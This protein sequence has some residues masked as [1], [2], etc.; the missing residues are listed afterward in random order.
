MGLAG[1]ATRGTGN[2][3]GSRSEFTRA[4]GFPI[5]TNTQSV[6]PTDGL[7]SAGYRELFKNKTLAGRKAHQHFTNQPQA[8]VTTSRIQMV[9]RLRKKEKFMIWRH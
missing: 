3:F 9:S 5:V 1:Y 6:R 8:T 2:A 7:L 4:P